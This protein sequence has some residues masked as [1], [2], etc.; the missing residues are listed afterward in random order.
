MEETD[1]LPHA[2]PPVSPMMI[3]FE[4]T[5]CENENSHHKQLHKFKI[6]FYLPIA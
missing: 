3:I 5:K 6:T 2:I 4:K 1:V